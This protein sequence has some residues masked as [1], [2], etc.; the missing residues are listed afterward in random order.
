MNKDILKNIID[1]CYSDDLAEVL[2]KFV[3]KDYQNSPTL[4][5]IIDNFYHDVLFSDNLGRKWQLKLH[6]VDEPTLLG[7][8][9]N[10]PTFLLPQLIGVTIQGFTQQTFPVY[11]PTGLTPEEVP[12]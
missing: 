12:F 10:T 5:E 2:L 1:L 11:V 3:K 6:G 7:L 4:L 9:K 8:T